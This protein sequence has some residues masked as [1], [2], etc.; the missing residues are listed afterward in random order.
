MIIKCD[1]DEKTGAVNASVNGLECIDDVLANNIKQAFNYVRKDDNPDRGECYCYRPDDVDEEKNEAVAQKAA[2]IR[3]YHESIDT[4]TRLKKEVL[5][6]SIDVVD[7]II[8]S[9]L[10]ILNDL[11]DVSIQNE[12]E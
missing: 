9:K 8:K 5:E 11:C 1:Y 7:D 3:Y 4:L 6:H 2:L 12:D 10:E